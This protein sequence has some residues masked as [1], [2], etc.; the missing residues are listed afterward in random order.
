MVGPFWRAVVCRVIG[1]SR[2][3]DHAALKLKFD[4]L[5]TTVESEIVRQV[6]QYQ[7]LEGG[8]IHP[9]GRRNHASGGSH[10]GTEGAAHEP[11]VGRG[12][13]PPRPTD[14]P[15]PHLP[16]PF[17]FHPPAAVDPGPPICA[18]G[19]SDGHVG[20]TEDPLHQPA[21]TE[22]ENERGG[23]QDHSAVVTGAGRP[24][25]QGK[26][27]RD[28]DDLT[29]LHPDVEGQKRPTITDIGTLIT[30]SPEVRDGRPC[31]AGTGVTV[32]RIVQV[33]VESG[34]SRLSNRTPHAGP[35]ICGPGVLPRQ[36]GGDGS[37]DG[38]R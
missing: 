34:G 3:G 13:T 12:P 9:A 36:S 22:Q 33:G 5:P 14:P 2:Q 30:H 17:A 10:S 16:A 24:R 21:D 7:L 28:D 32:Q 1:D 8:G 4:E 31:I 19:A 25:D 29:D 11:P 20:Q 15:A 6:F 23:R 35:G 18:G 27:Q 38:R 26:H 37:G